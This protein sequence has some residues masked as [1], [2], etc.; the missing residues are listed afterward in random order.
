MNEVDLFVPLLKANQINKLRARVVKDGRSLAWWAE[1]DHGST[2]EA[3]VRTNCSS[4][5][6]RSDQTTTITQAHEPQMS[7]IGT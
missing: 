3:Q 2:L 4:G 6:T 1:V 5:R 7:K